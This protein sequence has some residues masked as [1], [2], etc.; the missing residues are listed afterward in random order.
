MTGIRC[1][2]TFTADGRIDFR[3]L[4][5]DLAAVFQHK[6]R[7]P[8]DRSAGRDEDPRGNRDLR[9]AAVLQHIFD[10]NLPQCR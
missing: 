7:T 8:S 3:E 6:D 5:K 2:F 4:V 1:C 9:A 10:L